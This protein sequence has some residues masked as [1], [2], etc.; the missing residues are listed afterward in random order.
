MIHFLAPQ[1]LY[2]LLLLAIPVIIHLFNFRRYKKVLFTNVRF[3]QE[4]KEETSRVS[5]LKHL[6]IL[7]SRLLALLFLILAFAQPFIP[8]G[9]AAQGRTDEPVSVF[10][11]NSFSMD[12]VSSQG[13][14]LEMARLKAR[15]VIRSY[16][17]STRF[18]VLTNDFEAFQQRLVSRD[19]AVDEV[20]RIKLSPVSRR[21]SEVVLRQKEAF[22]SASSANGTSYIISDFQKSTADFNVVKQD[23]SL[24]ITLVALPLQETANV[25]IDSCWLSSPV[26]QI[27]QPAELSVRIR[28]SSEKDAENVPVRLLLNGSQKAVASLSIPSGQSVSTTFSFTISQP[29]WQKAELSITD[30]PIT[31]DD[32]YF[33]SFEVREKLNVL[34]VYEGNPSPYLPALF[35]N[36]PYFN[37]SSSGIGNVDYSGFAKQ[38]LIVVDDISTFS[39]GLSD[40][41][42]KYIDAGGSLCL[43]PDS[44]AELNSW[45]LF[46][47]LVGA[48]GISGLNTNADKVVQVEM[49]HPLFDGVFDPQKMK[50][51]KIDYPSAMKYFELAT[52]SQSRKQ[53]L[54][55]LQGGASF[56]SYYPAGRGNV[57]L[58]AVPLSPGFSNLSRHAIFAPLLY[59]MAVLS[60]K[61]FAFANTLGRTEPIV[62]NTAPPGGDE[63][64]H[65]VNKKLSSDII[66]GV[67]MMNSGLLIDVGE[68]ITSS[69]HFELMKGNV[70][71]A[72]LAFNFDRH[73]SLMTF[74][75]EDEISQELSNAGLSNWTLLKSTVQDVGK[76]LSVLN[77]GF[78]LWKYA[79]VLA[80]L[81]LLMETLL[82]RFWKT[83]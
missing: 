14:L 66:P 81:F 13:T 37:Y 40:E 4:L 77:K 31:F 15:E 11:D 12:A 7:L 36:D 19:D 33:F 72:V 24:N 54:M 75:T 44:A 8:S 9:Q 60:V 59:R 79:I 23:S 34:A 30:H 10:I 18:Q 49:Q 82:I 51:G 22:S 47:N 69:G 32:S 21:L 43:F 38:D 58:F 57:Y 55:K 71:N 27:N 56:L 1:Y 80:L 53:V 28:N 61:P 20:D 52:V 62:L 46:L 16:P 3:L 65:L 63:V 42:K 35:S 74:F 39:S 6:L 73:E 76:T 83:A 17:A 67:K 5:K 45:R 26:V 48:D 78:S 25:F 29:G 2:G 41:L 64:F 70:V 68:E 50:E